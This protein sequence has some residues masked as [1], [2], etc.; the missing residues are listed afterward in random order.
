MHP[1]SFV[2]PFKIFTSSEII[3][4]AYTYGNL[5]I[6]IEMA[7]PIHATCGVTC[8]VPDRPR[9]HPGGWEQA[10]RRIC[11]SKTADTDRRLIH[12]IR[13]IQWT[14]VKFILKFFHY[15]SHFCFTSHWMS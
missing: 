14:S 1:H 9:K 11:F 3:I 15:N 6:L 4:V 8:S 7:Q 5:R 13:M 2:E 12:M 10:I